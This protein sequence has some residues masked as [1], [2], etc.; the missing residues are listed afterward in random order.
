MK[1]DDEGDVYELTDQ[2]RTSFEVVNM[3]ALEGRNQSDSVM[4]VKPHHLVMSINHHTRMLLAPI[5]LL[6]PHDMTVTS[7]TSCPDRSTQ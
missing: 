5:I 6:A 3:F 7:L 4:I 2:G 1:P